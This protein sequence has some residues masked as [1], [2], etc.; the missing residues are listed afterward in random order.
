LGRHCKSKH[1]CR[2]ED[3]GPYKA[4]KRLYNID[5]KFYILCVDFDW[6]RKKA[7]KNLN[8]HK[9]SFEEASSV[10][11]DPLSDTFDDPD[12]SIDEKRFLIFGLSEQGRLLVV[13]HTDDGKTV[14]II[15][16]RVMTRSERE[17]YER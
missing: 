9:V 2:R 12:H 14:R 17:N 10:F 8:K 6:D 7:A 11:G 16:A 15:S 4:I 5:Q 13:A 3:F 1:E